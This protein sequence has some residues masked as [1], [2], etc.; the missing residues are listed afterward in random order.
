MVLNQVIDEDEL[1]S[2]KTGIGSGHAAN[3][4]EAE[5]ILRAELESAL[6]HAKSDV[7][8][9]SCNTIKQEQTV[10]IDNMAQYVAAAEVRFHG[11]AAVAQREFD[12]IAKHMPSD[13]VKAL[14]NVIEL[15]GEAYAARQSVND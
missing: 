7:V 6:V 15:H 11:E 4:A 12:T 3:Y 8:N 2:V 13:N 9:F 10:F 14:R 1:G 5:N